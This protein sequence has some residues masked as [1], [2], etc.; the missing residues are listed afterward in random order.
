[1]AVIAHPIAK[2]IVEEAL[3]LPADGSGE[4]KPV[5][6]A[7]GD[8]GEKA[9]ALRS[10]F[11][12]KAAAISSA[13]KRA[14]PEAKTDFV[15]SELKIGHGEATLHGT[16]SGMI[17]ALEFRSKL[18]QIGSQFEMEWEFPVPKTMVDGKRVEFQAR[19]IYQPAVKEEKGVTGQTEK[20]SSPD[21]AE[22]LKQM[23]VSAWNTVRLTS[24]TRCP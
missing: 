7:A 14:K 4:V 15:L 6:D 23:A 9:E 8:A 3:A 17:Q 18:E 2:R 1:V 19:G 5:G 12:A 16:A 11:D 24:A 13:I 10:A 22:R 20:L 21:P